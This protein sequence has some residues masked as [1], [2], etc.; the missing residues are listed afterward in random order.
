MNNES[1]AIEAF[2]GFCESNEIEDQSNAMRAF[3]S[4][5][6]YF[7]ILDGAF[8]S[9]DVSDN[10]L[11]IAT[12]GFDIKNIF[13][14][15]KNAIEAAWSWFITKIREI[16]EKIF[17][18]SK[19]KLRAE[20]E[21]L[22]NQNAG[23]K[24]DIE[25]QKEE[26]EKKIK[27][28][29]NK[30]KKASAEREEWKKKAASE[31][32]DKNNERNGFVTTINHMTDTIE[33]LAKELEALKKENIKLKNANNDKQE[34]SSSGT[35]VNPEK[36][37]IPILNQIFHQFESL[38]KLYSEKIKLSSY[39][40]DDIADGVK[41]DDIKN[42]NKVREKWIDSRN[43]KSGGAQY[44]SKIDELMDEFKEKS[45][46]TQSYLLSGYVNNI[47]KSIDKIVAD[48]KSIKDTFMETVNKIERK[49]ISGNISAVHAVT[50]SLQSDYMAIQ[51]IALKVCNLTVS[52]PFGYIKES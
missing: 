3:E 31:R 45:K 28:L 49:R 41:T 36:A 37:L 39:A 13:T 30:L 27:E 10:G 43:R 4:Y 18:K 32:A 2:I 5:N 46:D 40:I 23:L 24:S 14:T 1:I 52:L 16:K 9:F 21:D 11:S 29:E 51:N 26:N 47:A 17:G 35:S 50:S 38:Q 6:N 8:E 25:K 34:K 22:S 7:D 19:K 48:T 20:N 42:Y 15:I 33:Q 12:E 44:L